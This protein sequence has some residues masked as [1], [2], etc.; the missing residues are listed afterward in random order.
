VQVADE[1]RPVRHA[2]RGERDDL[3]IE[4]A[5]RLRRTL[6][7]AADDEDADG[8][9]LLLADLRDEPADEPVRQVR[10][11]YGSSPVRTSE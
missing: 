4:V 1:P 10:E 5:R 3:E 6:Y 7:V 9:R 8:V 2:R 11:L